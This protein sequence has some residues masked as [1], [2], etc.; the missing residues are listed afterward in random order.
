MSEYRYPLVYDP[1]QDLKD[2]YYSVSRKLIR[3]RPWAGDEAS[4]SQ[5]ISAFQFDKGSR[6]RRSLVLLLPNILMQNA[7]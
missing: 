4:K 3:S 7:K 2:R 5:A 6:S 1:L